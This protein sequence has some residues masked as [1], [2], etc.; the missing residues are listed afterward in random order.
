[1]VLQVS[2]NPDRRV[3]LVRI[4]LFV[5]SAYAL[6]GL[7]ALTQFGD[8]IL[9]FDKWA[10]LGSATGPFVNRNSF[11]T[12]LAIGVVIAVSLL[13]SEADRAD[14]RRR[15]S[16]FWQM[17]S[18]DL[19]LFSLCL[20]LLLA[21]LLATQ[22]RMGIFAAGC[23]VLTVLILA[24]RH[25]AARRWISALAALLVILGA[26]LVWAYGSGFM[27]RLSEALQA[28]DS[29]AELYSQVADMLAARPWLG[30]GGDSFEVAFPLFHQAPF[31][32][33][34]VWDKSHSTYL[35][36]WTEYGIIVG[37]VPLLTILLIARRIFCAL[38]NDRERRPE[39]TIALG[40]LVVVAVHST[41]D[42]SLEVEANA[43]LFVLLLG[44]GAGPAFGQKERRHG[45]AS[46]SRSSAPQPPK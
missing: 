13:I 23:G 46:R 18:S 22:S 19:A 8:T 28:A 21:T 40:A 26:L 41:I 11:A 4:V 10:Y 33:E 7:L 9:I 31:G 27:G 14:G 37:S 15:H 36:F 35:A 24:M 29:R 32:I 39:A 3:R 34:L 42:F 12:Y 1:L 43:L 20:A 38:R 25:A 30:Y 6:Y 2:V 17:P 44:L 5:I 45:A 16:S